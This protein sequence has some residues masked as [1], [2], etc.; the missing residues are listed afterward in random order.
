M[1]LT[2][3]ARFPGLAAELVRAGVG[4][5]GEPPPAIE[6]SRLP[7]VVQRYLSFMRVGAEVR[8]VSFVVGW[9]G[10]FRLRPRGRWMPFDAI[11]YDACMGAT[12]FWRMRLRYAGVPIVARDTYVRGRGRMVGRVLDR[13][14]VVDAGGPEL[15]T[16][17]LVTFLNDAILLAPSMLLDERT[18]WS[19]VDDRAFDVA[20]SDRGR[21][22]GARVSVNADGAVRDFS[23]TDR[24]VQDPY[25]RGHPFVRARWSTPIG[26]WRTVH[27]R[28]VP[29]R[30][31][32]VWHLPQGDFVYAEMSPK[33][34]HLAFETGAA[35]CRPSRFLGSTGPT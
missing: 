26:A 22:V 1:D 14:S 19:A 31:Q 12:R 27:G 30:G 4:A 29:V 20:F 5:P 34:D 17:E 11:Q 16:G 15:D 21:K 13:F 32:A 28:R 18:G 23:T 9:S 2:T 3:D 33:L 24:F 10:R 6:L 35:G 8:D 7:E 25:R